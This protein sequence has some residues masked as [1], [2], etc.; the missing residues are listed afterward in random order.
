MALKHFQLAAAT[1][2]GSGDGPYNWG[3]ALFTVAGN[4]RDKGNEAGGLELYRQAR[5]RFYDARKAGH[6][7]AP[8]MIERINKLLPAEA[9]ARRPPLT[10]PPLP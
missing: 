4:E 7:G 8:G 1:D 5:S 9:N 3:V 2:D 6:R 10:P